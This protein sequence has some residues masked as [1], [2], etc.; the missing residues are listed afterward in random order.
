[1]KTKSDIHIRPASINDRDFI[2][3]LVPRLTEFGVPQ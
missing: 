2:I 3:S 1:M